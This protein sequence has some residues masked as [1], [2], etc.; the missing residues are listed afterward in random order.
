MPPHRAFLCV[1]LV[2]SGQ[3][4]ARNL[5]HEIAERVITLDTMHRT[6]NYRLILFV[7]SKMTMKPV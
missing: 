1:T 2:L 3:I 6:I 5:S 7:F 4:T